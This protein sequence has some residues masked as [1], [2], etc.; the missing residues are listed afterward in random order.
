M[1]TVMVE[2]TVTYACKLSEEDEQKFREYIKDTDISMKDAILEL[3]CGGKINLY[4]NSTESDFDTNDV[5][6]I[7]EEGE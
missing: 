5:T 4:K 1:M 7:I 3:Y 6:E 2:A